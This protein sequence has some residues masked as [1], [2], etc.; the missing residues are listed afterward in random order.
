MK[1]K[2]L[3][4]SLLLSLGYS[5]QGQESCGTPASSIPQH[6]EDDEENL[7]ARTTPEGL[8]IN[9]FFH[10]VR[11]SNGSGGF[12]PANINTIVQNLNE[13]FNPHRIYINN[14]GVDFINSSTYYN[15][16]SNEFNGLISTNN[17]S[18]AINFYLVNSAP[19]AGRAQD[20]LSKNLVVVNNS[21]LSPTSPHELGHCLN[22]WHTHHG[23]GCNDT[24]GCTEN[25]NGSNCSTCGDF[26][27]DTP[28][29]PCVLG[30]VDGNC[31]Y[32]GG[33]GFNPDVTNIMSYGGWCRT[34]FS[35]GQS[36]RMRNAIRFSS[37]FQS[38]VSSNGCTIPELIGDYTICYSTN[39][40]TYSLQ[41]GG[42]SVLWNVSSNLQILSSSNTSIT[43]RPT[44]SSTI[45]AGFIEA[46]LP[47]ETIREDIWIGT[48]KPTGFVSV[49][50]D[51]WLGRIKARVEPV[52]DA[53]GYIWYLDGVQYTGP[54]MNSDYVTMPISR[55]N[56]TIPDYSIGVMA[57]NPCGTSVGHFELHENPC[58]E[59]EFYYSYSPNPA[60]ETLTVERVDQRDSKSNN[61]TI[62]TVHQYKLHDFNGNL[63]QEG[64]LS[65]KTEIDVSKLP[66][67]RYIL[68]IHIDKNN[69]ETHHISIN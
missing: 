19:Y 64:N 16:A 2:F 35:G 67:G 37:T 1:L 28:A 30:Q 56:C 34:N 21:A 29:D 44:N 43:V 63:V 27:C 24:G 61:N 10:I 55:N 3:L 41:N 25:I 5:T 40:T 15:L 53:T 58:Y 32:T 57:I 51:P 46:V 33:G 48:H 31:Q 54:G 60:S 11:E 26:V 45:G 9:V 59:G 62:T 69:R 8:C 65:T 20:I 12:N 23:R 6:F 52:Q 66:D 50:V 39:G 22:L 49:I 36:N 47:L 17:V 4:L 42:N 38:V 68:I 18:N 14:L 13:V 7:S